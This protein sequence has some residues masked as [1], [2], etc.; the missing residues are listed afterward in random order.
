M[1]APD[2]GASPDPAP[3]PRDSASRPSPSAS[4]SSVSARSPVLVSACLL[5]RPCR[6]DG[7]DSTDSTLAALIDGREV[8]PVCPEELGG[9]GTPR[10]PAEIVGSGDDPG[11]TG[12]T[13]I[14]VL[15]GT[16]RVIDRTG[17]DV[18]G[19]FLEGARAAAA[20]GRA[21]GVQVAYLKSRSPSCGLGA[22]ASQGTTRSG[23]GVFAELLRRSG[24]EIVPCEGRRAKPAAG[25]P[26]AGSAPA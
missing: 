24:V 9:L 4:T 18:T 25:E 15:D 6:F 13:G 3:D 10:E 23:N 12:A 19:A 16:A 14:E 5:G 20:E 2:P 22:L 11:A 17:R 21:A 1:A 8:V 7:R 26:A